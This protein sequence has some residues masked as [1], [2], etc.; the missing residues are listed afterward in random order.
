M[1]CG[2]VCES[3]ETQNVLVIIYLMYQQNAYIQLNTCIII[4]TVL[5][6]SAV[7]APS[8][9]GTLWYPQNYCYVIR[10]QILSWR[11]RE[12]TNLFTVI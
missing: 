9:G 11:I 7:L 6:I 2:V 4:S 3:R 12:F 10:L 1:K 8:S 5:H